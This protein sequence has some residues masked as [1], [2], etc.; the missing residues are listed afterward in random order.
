[1]NLIIFCFKLIFLDFGIDF[2]VF[3]YGFF[4]KYVI[5]D[6]GERFILNIII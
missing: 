5:G 2:N 4:F 1:M 6:V 3:S